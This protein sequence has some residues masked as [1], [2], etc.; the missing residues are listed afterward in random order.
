M[1]NVSTPTKFQVTVPKQVHDYLYY[2]ASIGK[3]GSSVP[4]VATFILIEAVNQKLADGWHKP[5]VPTPATGSLG[6][7]E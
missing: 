7:G 1:S 6:A 4:D 5:E 2:L 3:G